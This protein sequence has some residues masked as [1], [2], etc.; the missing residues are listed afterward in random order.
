MSDD[1]T[2]TTLPQGDLR[3]LDTP[4]AV[5]LLASA[6]P[7]RLA[8]VAEDGTPRVVPTWFHWNGRRAGDAHVLRRAAHPPAGA[9]HRQPARQPRG[10]PVDRHRRPPPH[11]LLVRGRGDDRGRRRGRPRVRLVGSPLPRRRGGGRPVVDGRRPRAPAW[12]ASPCA[13]SGS[14]CSTSTRAIPAP[15]GADVACRCRSAGSGPGRADARNPF[16]VDREVQPLLVEADER[17]DRHG[18]VEGVLV[19]PGDVGEHAVADGG[20]VVRGRPL[21]GA[22][23]AVIAGAQLDR[24]RRPPAGSSGPRGTRLRT[25]CDSDSTR[26]GAHPR[27]RGARVGSCAGRRCGG[28]GRVGGRRSARPPPTSRTRRS[29]APGGCARRRPPGGTRR[30]DG[31]RR[32]RRRRTGPPP[33]CAPRTGCSDRAWA[34]RRHRS[35]RAGAPGAAGVRSAPGAWRRRRRPARRTTARRASAPTPAGRSSCRR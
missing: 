23:G 4:V 21:V 5:Q 30:R 17:P 12:P 22:L 35:R 3:L 19:A 7:A 15:S 32:R 18:V 31:P 16:A 33:T 13:P 28:T 9:A 29:P 20:G 26:P 25:A 8:Y 24:A 11:V 6:I 14:A 10:R 1:T 2:T 27:A 34:D